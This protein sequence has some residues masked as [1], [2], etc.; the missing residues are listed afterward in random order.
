MYREQA[1]SDKWVDSLLDLMQ[2]WK[3][4]AWAEEAGQIEKGVGPFI[5][6][7]QRDRKVWGLRV[8]FS[9]AVNKEIRARALQ[10]MILSGKIRFPKDEPWW[11]DMKNELLK[12]PAG[13][14][15]DMVDTLTLL[16]RM[17]DEMRKGKK[18]KSEQEKKVLTIGK[19]STITYDDLI[20]IHENQVMESNKNPL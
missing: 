12:F 10:A 3:T 15:D 14:N 16:C 8:P 20:K 7:S 9:S 11:G 1:A 6:K 13:K 4:L 17:L 19:S 18:K 5:V 2:F